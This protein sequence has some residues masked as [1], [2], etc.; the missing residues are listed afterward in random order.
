[1]HDSRKKFYCLKMIWVTSME[2]FVWIW[3]FYDM[4]SVGWCIYVQ[5]LV[6]SFN[7]RRISYLFVS[8]EI[9]KWYLLLNDFVRKY[10]WMES[11]VK[12][13]MHKISWNLGV[14]FFYRIEGE[15]FT[16]SNQFKTKRRVTRAN[17][18]WTLTVLR[19]FVS[20]KIY[21]QTNRKNTLSK[22]NLIVSHY[23]HTHTF[24][25]I[26]SVCTKYEYSKYTKIIHRCRRN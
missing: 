26:I 13:H 5:S 4:I 12:C 19:L 17:K 9:E 10:V 18:K 22:K 2:F 15:N 23:T 7:L 16:V 25:V 8:R 21:Q 6:G 3:C 14:S 1:M 11:F 24:I 20:L